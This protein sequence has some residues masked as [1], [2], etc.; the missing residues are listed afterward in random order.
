MVTPRRSSCGILPQ[1]G[2]SACE[3]AARVHGKD[4]PL[5]PIWES[6]RSPADHSCSRLY[7]SVP[8]VGG[9]SLKRAHLKDEAVRANCDGAHEDA[10]EHLVV[11]VRLSRADVRELPLKVCAG[12]VFRREHGESQFYI[13]EVQRFRSTPSA[14]S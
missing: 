10:V 14:S 9:Q 7:A 3:R 2:A 4:E 11:L 12:D 8:R 5:P 13:R 6:L 1:F